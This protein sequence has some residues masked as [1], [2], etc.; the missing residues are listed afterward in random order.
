MR[1]GVDQVGD[2][3]LV[4]QPRSGNALATP[5]LGPEFRGGHGLHI[6]RRAHGEDELLVVDQVLDVQV[7]RVVDHLA[8][9]RRGVFVP[10]GSQLVLDDRPEPV[11]VSEDDL[12]L[13]DGGQELCHTIL[14][15]AA[16][17]PGESDQLHVQD[18][19]GLD[20]AELEPVGHQAVTRRAPV[21]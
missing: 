10:D 12:Q 1:R 7:A 19:V 18:V 6:A 17:Q 8:A 5:A 9:T 13:G 16:T 20:L 2:R 14:E 3:I 21:R 15:V 4:L 11:L